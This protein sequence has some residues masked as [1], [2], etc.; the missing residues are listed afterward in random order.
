MEFK[1]NRHRY[2]LFLLLFLV[3]GAAGSLLSRLHD[4]QIEQQDIARERIPGNST[5]SIRTPGVRGIITDRTGEVIL[6]KNLREYEVTLNLEEI[7]AAYRQEKK[8]KITFDTLGRDRDGM[9]EKRSEIDIVT[10]FE[11]Y[12]RPKL[13]ELGIADRY[14][15]EELRI[16]FKSHEGLIPFRYPVS[17]TYDQFA[18]LAENTLD[19]P[20]VYVGLKPKRYYPY[21]TLACHVIGYLKNYEKGSI[22]LAEKKYDY[23]HYF[24]DD[25]GIMGVESTMNERL[26]GLPGVKTVIK[27]DK[28]RVIGIQ[29]LVPPGQGANVT[30]T[31]DARLQY[32]VENILRQ[33][34][35]AAAVVMDVHTGEVLAMASIP[36]YNPNEFIGGISQTEFDVYNTNK[37]HPFINRC[38]S[39]YMPG[40]TYKLPMALIACMDGRAVKT[41]PSTATGKVAMVGLN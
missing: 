37:A 38:I 11:Q 40:S 9:P 21:G 17:L 41:N 30:L 34:G 2:R 15:K 33:A 23:D 12:V 14:N 10:V 27:N 24:G 8:E 20:G 3:L 7:S 39:A 16:H 31:I 28:R 26:T 32:T 13:K 18:R 25:R 29:D 36:N 4:V 35:R 6:A 5:V 22:P 1:T 19:I